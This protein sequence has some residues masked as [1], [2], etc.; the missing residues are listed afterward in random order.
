MSHMLEAILATQNLKTAKSLFY[1]SLMP[2]SLQLY[3]YMKLHSKQPVK[4]AAL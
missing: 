1:S 4:L 2:A 3:R